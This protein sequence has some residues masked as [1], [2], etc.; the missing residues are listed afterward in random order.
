[1]PHVLITG[2]SR[3]LGLGLA[4][5]YLQRGHA[6]T[7][8]GREQPA[9]DAAV[10]LLRPHGPV[11]ALALDAGDLD[12]TVK[13]LRALDERVGG[14][15]VVIANAGVGADPSKGAPYSWEAIA[16]ALHVNFTGAAA[17]LTAVLPAMVERRRGHLVGI[18][19]LASYGALPNAAAYCAP[20]AGLNMLLDCLALD[21][22]G[23]GVAVTTVKLG[24]V[25]TR[26]VETATHP[27][28]QLMEVDDAARRVVRAL[29]ARPRVVTVPRALAFG[30]WV[31]GALPLAVKA[32]LPR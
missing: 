11:A 21:T 6:V 22:R 24:F 10:A 19:S 26:M 9:L 29:E 30:A 18:S 17:T 2:G 4:R 28:P 16:Q 32:K 1:M 7:I 27:M 20:K 14:L 3:G 12:A 15:D 5:Q 13:G 25:K 31:G 8:T 23:T